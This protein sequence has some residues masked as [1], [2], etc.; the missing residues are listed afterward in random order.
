MIFLLEVIKQFPNWPLAAVT[1]KKKSSAHYAIDELYKK[2]KTKH[3]IMHLTFFFLTIA[4][5]MKF[6]CWF[7]LSLV[8]KSVYFVAQLYLLI[9]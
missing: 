9:L 5:R 6:R 4:L 1:H 2:N 8:Y 3:V 7:F